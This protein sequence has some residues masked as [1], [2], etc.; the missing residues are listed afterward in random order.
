MFVKLSLL[1]AL[2]LFAGK[3][4]IPLVLRYVAPVSYTHLRD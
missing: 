4:I 3:K 1:V 2:T